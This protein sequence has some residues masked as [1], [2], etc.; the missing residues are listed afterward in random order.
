M[1]QALLRALCPSTCR[2]LMMS[3]TP[4]AKCVGGCRHVVLP[5]TS[6]CGM[7]SAA[8]GSRQS[9][10]TLAHPAAAVLAAAGRRLCRT[11]PASRRL[12]A[13]ASA[14][15]WHGE[16]PPS[17]TRLYEYSYTH[18]HQRGA[19][20]HLGTTY[21]MYTDQGRPN[22]REVMSACVWWCAGL[23]RRWLSTRRS[24]W[25]ARTSSATRCSSSTE[26]GAPGAGAKHGR[27]A[28]GPEARGAAPLLAGAPG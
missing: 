6:T 28:G 14:Q 11:A 21:S 5:A 1:D 27:R 12:T 8:R 25:S 23:R 20:N 19:G 17:M 3:S 2:E 16:T 18:L 26:R 15:H 22:H 4:A 10:S 7:L 13:C 24:S 9:T